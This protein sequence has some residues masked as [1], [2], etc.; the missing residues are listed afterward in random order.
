MS[1]GI[2]SENIVHPPPQKKKHTKKTRLTYPA[3]VLHVT[4]DPN[5]HMTLIEFRGMS[6]LGKVKTKQGGNCPPIIF[7][8]YF[9]HLVICRYM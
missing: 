7:Y 1:R 2:N 6:S 4:Y 9:V 3:P 8:F 5:N